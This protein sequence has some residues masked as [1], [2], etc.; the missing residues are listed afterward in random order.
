MNE[1]RTK[2]GDPK[3]IV[4]IH[5]T[6]VIGGQNEAAVDLS[7]WFESCCWIYPRWFESCCWLSFLVGISNL[8]PLWKKKVCDGGGGKE[9]V[10]GVVLYAGIR[11]SNSNPEFV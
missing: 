10:V 2:A 11:Y 7:R 8:F 3:M 1:S 9:L 5:V 6:I 4:E